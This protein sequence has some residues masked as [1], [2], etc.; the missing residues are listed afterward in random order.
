[1]YWLK[2]RG[3]TVWQPLLIMAPVLCQLMIS[4]M[5]TGSG[6]V[7]SVGVQGFSTWYF[8]VVYGEKEYGRFVGRKTPEAQEAMRRFP[9]L[10]DKLMYVAKNY[11]I[12]IKTYVDLLLRQH[13]IVQSNFVNAGLSADERNSRVLPK[14]QKLSARLNLLFACVHAVMLA[15]MILV[16]VSGR[17]LYAEKAMLACYMFAVLLIV[18]S[19]LAYW[20]GDRYILLSEPL[21]LV[22]YGNLA[23]LVIAR[24]SGRWIASPIQG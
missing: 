17:P 5:V 8:P 12:A 18:P 11:D 20:Q 14:L 13:L 3:R 7:A 1:M 9:E 21:W 22:A 2:D 19:P 10:K 4:S 16:V 6:A 15:L 24:W 23:S